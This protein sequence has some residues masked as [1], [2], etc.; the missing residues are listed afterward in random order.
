MRKRSPGYFR[1][2]RKKAEHRHFE[3]LRSYGIDFPREM[4]DR[5]MYKMSK[6]KRSLLKKKPPTTNS[7]D[8]VKHSTRKRLLNFSPHETTASY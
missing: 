4:I 7:I 6:E 5:L 8:F 3:I 2:Q 1:Y